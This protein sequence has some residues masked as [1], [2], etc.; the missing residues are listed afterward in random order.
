AIGGLRRGVSFFSEFPSP[1]AEHCVSKCQL[2]VGNRLPTVSRFQEGGWWS[3]PSGPGATVDDA[4]D[5]PAEIPIPWGPLF[6][7]LRVSIATVTIVATR[8]SGKWRVGRPVLTGDPMGTRRVYRADATRT[9]RVYTECLP[10][11]PLWWRTLRPNRASQK[12]PEAYR[13]NGS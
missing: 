6:L 12:A 3:I 11:G 10:F 1:P 4:T 5:Q 9:Q 7:L 13:T 8:W 2:D